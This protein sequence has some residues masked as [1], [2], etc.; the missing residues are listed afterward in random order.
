MISPGD[1]IDTLIFGHDEIDRQGYH[2]VTFISGGDRGPGRPGE[3][4]T[5][6]RGGRHDP[7]HRLREDFPA[8]RDRGF[9]GDTARERRWRPPGHGR[10]GSPGDRRESARDDLPAGRGDRA[11]RTRDP[12]LPAGGVL[13][14]SSSGG[15][16]SSE[17]GSR[18]RDVRRPMSW[19]SWAPRAGRR[20]SRRPGQSRRPSGRSPTTSRDRASSPV[21]RSRTRSWPRRASSS[22]RWASTRGA[23]ASSPRRRTPSTSSRA[24]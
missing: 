12:D 15:I 9:G 2:P 7:R 20:S 17:A 24:W 10:P 8:A 19:R 1:E 18:W 3:I 22:R 13:P 23:S 5:R 6:R 11:R 4:A 16:R 14:S 21:S